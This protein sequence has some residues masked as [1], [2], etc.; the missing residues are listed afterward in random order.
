MSNNYQNF[1]YLFN[2]D[3]EV[4]VKLPEQGDTLHPIANLTAPE[5][6]GDIGEGGAAMINFGYI[7][8]NYDDNHAIFPAGLKE[9]VTKREGESFAAETYDLGPAGT[10]ALTLTNDPGNNPEKVHVLNPLATFAEGS[11]YEFVNV[12]GWYHFG[13]ADVKNTLNVIIDLNIN[14]S[15]LTLQRWYIENESLKVVDAENNP[16]IYSQDIWIKTPLLWTSPNRKKIRKYFYYYDKIF[17]NKVKDYHLVSYASTNIATKIGV[18][19]DY[20]VMLF[21]DKGAKTIGVD[22]KQPSYEKIYNY[23]DAQYEP[24]VIDFIHQNHADE[25]M[26]PSIYD[27]L[28]KDEQPNLKLFWKI[29]GMTGGGV[30]DEDTNLAN[31]N[32]YLDASAK[33]LYSKWLNTSAA[34]RIDIDKALEYVIPHSIFGEGIDPAFQDTISKYV[35]PTAGSLGLGGTWIQQLN[36]ER[37]F[38]LTNKRKLFLV[39]DSIGALS[40]D[41]VVNKYIDVFKVS[42][43]YYPKWIGDLKTGIYFSEKS[44]GPDGLF[45][46]TLDKD[47]VFPFLIKL[48]IPAETRG[49][50]AKLLSQQDLLDTLNIY[51]ASLTIPNETGISTYSNFYGG[52]LNG[53][54]AGTMNFFQE[55]SL[56]SFKILFRKPHNPAGILGKEPNAAL[57]V[58]K[59]T[60]NRLVDSLTLHES[61]GLSPSTD[62][63][64]S[65][66]PLGIEDIPE[67]PLYKNW[68]KLYETPAYVFFDIDGDGLMDIAIVKGSGHNNIRLLP[69]PTKVPTPG[70]TVILSAYG[71]LGPDN[72]TDLFQLDYR[73]EDG[74]SPYFWFYW[75]EAPYSANNLPTIQ[76][77]LAWPPTG[78]PNPYNYD[79]VYRNRVNESTYQPPGQEGLDISLGKVVIPFVPISALNLTHIIEAALGGA[80]LARQKAFGDLFPN[81]LAGLAEEVDKELEAQA[82]TAAFTANHQK[83]FDKWKSIHVANFI[84]KYDFLSADSMPVVEDT[85]VGGYSAAAAAEAA[86]VPPKSKFI[87]IQT[88]GEVPNFTPPGAVCDKKWDNDECKSEFIPAEDT[89]DN[90]PAYKTDCYVHGDP[91]CVGILISFS[92]NFSLYGERRIW[93]MAAFE[94]VVPESGGIEFSGGT[95]LPSE[96]AAIYD[97]ADVAELSVVEILPTINMASML[98]SEKTYASDIYIDNLGVYDNIP[99]DIL[100]YRGKEQ[101]GLTNNSSIQAL[102]NKLKT[103]S[104]KKKLQ[105]LFTGSDLLR[106]PADIQDGKLAHQETLMYEIA[107]Y[108]VDSQG[109]EKYIQSIFLP[110]T[111]EAQLSYYD[112]QIVPY[113]NYFY[114]IFAHKAILGTEYEFKPFFALPPANSKPLTL[115]KTGDMYDSTEKLAFKAQYIVVPYLEIVRVPYYNTEAVNIKID[116]LNY[117]R[118]EDSPPLAPQVNIVPFRNINNRILILM[119]NSIGQVDQY[120]KIIFEEDKEIFENA[121]LAQDK[122]LS[123]T[124]LLFKSDDSQGSFQVFRIETPPTDYKDFADDPTLIQEELYSLGL[125]KNDSMLDHIVPNKNYY[126]SFRFKDIHENISNPTDIYKVR[127][128]QEIAAIPYLTIDLIDIGDLKKK[129]Y[130]EKFSPIKKMQKYLYIQPSVLQNTMTTNPDPPQESNYSDTT[131]TLG[132]PEGAAVFGKNFKLRITSAQTGRKLDINLKVN[133]PLEIINE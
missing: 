45:N 97:Q 96:A 74:A 42:Q 44:C 129:Q 47:F 50:I 82:E 79:F 43:N 9:N 115:K 121:A 31:F 8:E 95:L 109:T 93:T 101:E 80:S 123:G 76:P 55:L 67:N 112:T 124:Q 89:L 105:Q 114:K 119:N 60:A 69:G 65:A 110:I 73:I 108:G 68:T 128:V 26:L 24:V 23:Y 75:V 25:K 51:A 113:K 62:V 53:T 81:L 100:V 85:G 22:T 106:T 3:Q 16:F 71:I 52:S 38:Q 48:N 11:T 133:P 58:N 40:A 98:F 78:R 19:Y 41:Y 126:Y 59:P 104:F 1:I 34:L 7:D 92:H 102:I 54:D 63:T 61:Q 4:K 17:S 103:M 116:K 86:G 125:E 127:M 21:E 14:S 46:Q 87:L 29:P 64:E 6:I 30:E 57:W 13:S 5:L 35:L 70:E 83:M 36:F 77:K 10:E 122:P 2:D 120:P 56:P 15:D 37:K 132:N 72:D 66:I 12:G 111:E 91:A 84:K 99:K 28:Y 33:Q 130:D 117:S 20:Q 94:E 49:P 39:L 118:V 18:P 88:F 107:K 27:F 131:V 90:L 32:R